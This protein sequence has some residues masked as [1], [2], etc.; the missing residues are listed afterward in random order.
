VNICMSDRFSQVLGAFVSYI[1]GF[2]SEDYN[3]RL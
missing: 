2:S 1:Y 3:S